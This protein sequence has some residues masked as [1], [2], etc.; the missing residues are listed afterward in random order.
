MWNFLEKLVPSF[1]RR[2]DHW[3]L[4]RDPLLWATR[5]IYVLY[6]AAGIAAMAVTY[7]L[8]APVS[9]GSN[10]SIDAY[11]IWWMV[12]VAL[13]VITWMLKVN[14][15][16]PDKYFG[17][18]FTQTAFRLQVAYFAGLAALVAGPVIGSH[19]L[20]YRIDRSFSQAELAR[21]VDALNVGAYM[22][23]SQA[24]DYGKGMPVIRY[25]VPYLET[26]ERAQKAVKAKVKAVLA[27]G[28]D[29]DDQQV[30]AAYYATL[31]KYHISEKGFTRL[32]RGLVDWR[33]NDDF[34][35]GV[36]N[37]LDRLSYVKAGRYY[38]SVMPWNVVWV[39][40]AVG[41]G[42]SLG[43]SVL[44]SIAWNE[45]GV[46]LGLVFGYLL[47]NGIAIVVVELLHIGG[48]MEG[49]LFLAMTL[50]IYGFVALWASW[51]AGT[52][53]WRLVR[54]GFLSL[55]PLATPVVPFLGYLLLREL[56]LIPRGTADPFDLNH[57]LG[58]LLVYVGA[59]LLGWI[60]WVWVFRPRLAA[61]RAM[62]VQA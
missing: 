53:R 4:L 14:T 13:A 60:S 38:L 19:V 27:S 58:Y 52:N 21:D 5:I 57:D 28:T 54:I 12:P 2:A 40:V 39:L 22:I 29:A 15:Y 26:G 7:S 56:H 43:L 51:R 32:H 45:A 30:L 34:D 23:G 18:A 59:A 37:R 10:S 49:M 50:S 9:G 31:R 48:R 41:M 62:P 46:A 20:V 55:L 47:F 35:Q 8:V 24:F 17:S 11:V 61:L 1:V 36:K 3:L 33:N 6:A 16:R 44:G 25:Q 42:F